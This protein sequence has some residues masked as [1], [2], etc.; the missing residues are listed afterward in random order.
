MNRRIFLQLCAT[1]IFLT[2]GVSF[3]QD[4]LSGQELRRR[5]TYDKSITA[6][7]IGKDPNVELGTTNTPL[8]FG[9]EKLIFEFSKDKERIVFQPKGQPY[10][11][12][13]DFNIFSPDY[14]YVA[15][16]QDHY[17]PY[18]IIPTENLRDYLLGKNTSFEIVS[19]RGPDGPG[20]IHGNIKWVSNDT[21]EFSAGCCGGG[22]MVVH[23][24]GGKTKRE[25]WKA[26]ERHLR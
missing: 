23:K 20:V 4:N 13:W 22:Y 19:G 11:S 21:V 9:V 7:W 10:F 2:S 3:S 5:T 18:H 15:L 8:E 26:G 6:I 1:I 24:I 16:L 25:K 14:R 17:G 12:N